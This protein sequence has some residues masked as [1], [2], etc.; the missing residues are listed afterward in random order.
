MQ[1][2]KSTAWVDMQ[3]GIAKSEVSG[4]EAVGAMMRMMTTNTIRRMARSKT[5]DLGGVIVKVGARAVRLGQR[6]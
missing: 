4:V 5:S 3:S 2:T 6:R 1:R